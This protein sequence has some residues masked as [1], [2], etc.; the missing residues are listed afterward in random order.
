MV[1]RLLLAVSIATDSIGTASLLTFTSNKSFVSVS[2][3]IG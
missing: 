2:L 1:I 3:M